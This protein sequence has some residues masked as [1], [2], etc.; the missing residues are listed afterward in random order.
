MTVEEMERQRDSNAR[1][2]EALLY[3]TG[4]YEETYVGD[5]A[6]AAAH[7]TLAA[8]WESRVTRAVPQHPAE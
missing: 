3:G 4:R 8:M 1:A 6:A 7:A 2:A 5:M